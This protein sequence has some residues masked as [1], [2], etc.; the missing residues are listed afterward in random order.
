MFANDGHAIFS[1]GRLINR[2]GDIIIEDHVWIG[3]HV[4]ILKDSHLYKNTI[5]G[6]M[7]LVTKNSNDHN[8]KEEGVVI[9]GNPGK[10]I[11]NNCTWDRKGPM[12]FINIDSKKHTKYTIV[13][14]GFWGATL[15]ERIATVLKEPVTII[16]RRGHTWRQLSYSVKQSLNTLRLAF[17]PF[18]SMGLY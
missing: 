16:D 14:A 9:S 13:G 5:V 8:K 3:Y 2:P 6:A 1:N 15:A 4:T 7:S 18:V 10:I 17:F 12:N 11:K